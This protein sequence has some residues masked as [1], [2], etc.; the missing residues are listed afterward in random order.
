MK[1][2]ARFSLERIVALDQAVRAGKYPNAGTIARALEVGHRTVQRDVEFMRDRLGAPL[3]FDSRR[4]GYY[5]AEPDYRLP[6]LSLTEGE[7][8]ALFLAERALQQYRGT[9]YAADLA[10]AFRKVTLGL[11]DQVTVDLGH[12]GEAHSFRTTASSGLDP[13]LFRDLAAA[14]RGR[15]R[16]ALRYFTASRD[17]ETAREVDPY[18]LAS[19]DGQW[20]LVG[21]CHLRGEVRMFA[22]GRIRALEPTGATFEPPAGFRIDDYLS[23]SFAVLRGG[24]GEVH[25]VRLRFTGEAV[26]YVQERP[27]H[28]SQTLEPV[29]DGG[30]LLSMELGHLREVE[31]FALSWGA[32]CE[33]LEPAEL[34]ER[35]ARH[36]AKAS[37]PYIPSVAERLA[38][39]SS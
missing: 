32:D 2:A 24:E 8:V 1:I 4:N 14:I 23:M 20:Y 16:L 29:G 6:V 5:Y 38:A 9:P 25:R 15:R 35:V 17:Q 36:L 33:V 13:G 26:K 18:H 19:V 12:L 37:A 21:H 27:W 10:R 31:R 28:A 3:A 39:S 34:R 30:L 11:S 22:P 7:L